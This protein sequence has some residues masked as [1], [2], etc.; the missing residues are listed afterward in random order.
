MSS[1][2]KTD[3]GSERPSPRGAIGLG[4]LMRA[5][6]GLD[7]RERATVERI[8]RSLGFTGL[9]ANPAEGAQGVSGAQRRPRLA[10]RPAAKAPTQRG[11]M[12]Q[13][14]PPVDLPEQ[15]FETEMTPVESPELP[16]PRP[17]WLDQGPALEESGLAPIPR[18]KLFPDRSAKGVLGAA[19]ATRRP[20]PNPDIDRLIEAIVRGGVLDAL[21]YRP[22]PSLHRGLQLLM[23]T[24]EAMTP[25][26]L[27]LDD[28]AHA[29]VRI[30]GRHACELYEFSADPNRAVRWSA[31]FRE[32]AWR[33]LAGRPVVVAT[34]FGI[35]ARIGARD[36]ANPRV[37][38]D[39]ERRAR[40]AGVPVIALV[41]YGRDRWR[42]TLSRR[43]HF[44]HWDPRTRASHISKMFGIGHEVDP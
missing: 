22:N 33:P 42:R 43:I 5:L 37:W 23:D 16:E 39:F 35:G 9:D 32:I 10:K 4:D 3:K 20:G 36:H 41:P 8:A 28:L 34:D 26:L 21:P 29:F 25:F 15:I 38:L 30:V 12:P 17:Q 14:A 24:G 13:V 2:K 19:I 11:G 1:A 7:S 18:A 44:I 27:D 40:A 31:D 6:K